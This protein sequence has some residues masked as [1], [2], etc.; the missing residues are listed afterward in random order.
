M[1]KEI[2]IH[3][4]KF[5]FKVL[6][7]F[8]LFLNGLSIHLDGFLEPFGCYILVA[9][10]IICIMIILKFIEEGIRI[11]MTVKKFVNWIFI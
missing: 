2:L 6:G 5:T 10:Y 11:K 3:F 8:F 9:C 1:E 7:N 4:A